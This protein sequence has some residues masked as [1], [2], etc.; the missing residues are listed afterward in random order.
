M[1]AVL[2]HLCHQAIHLY[3]GYYPLTPSGGTQYSEDSQVPTGG[4]YLQDLVWRL[5]DAAV[6]PETCPTSHAV[7]RLGVVLGPWGGMVGS[8][9]HQM[10]FNLGGTIGSGHQVVSWIHLDDLAQLF[11][12]VTEKGA[13]GAFN[14]TSPKPI[15]MDKMIQAFANAMG[16]KAVLWSPDLLMKT[17]F[18]G[19]RANILLKGNRVLPKRALDIGFQ[20]TYSHIYDAFHHIVQVRRSG[21]KQ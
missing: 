1:P 4:G 5:E 17:I 9:W 10:N 6:L 8:L 7:L 20:F 18:D 14:A 11:L 13:S 3:A 15:T 2:T 12:F 19:P 21:H 16:R